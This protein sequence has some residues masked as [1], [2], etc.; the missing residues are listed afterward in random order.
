MFSDL[1][2]ETYGQKA[3]APFSFRVHAQGVDANVADV[4]Y[5][6]SQLIPFLG[7]VVDASLEKDPKHFLFQQPEDHLHPRAQAE[8]ASFIA[9]AAKKDGHTFLVETHSDFIVDRLR[10]CMADGLI[11]PKDVALLYFEPQKSKGAVKFTQL[12]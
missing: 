5:G 3:D 7:R 6:I 1:K 12:S 2:L 4:G 10:I 8:F 11:D 9:N